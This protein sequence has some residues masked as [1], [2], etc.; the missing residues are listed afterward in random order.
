MLS[1]LLTYGVVHDIIS[2]PR[3]KSLLSMRNKMMNNGIKKINRMKEPLYSEDI[4]IKV[5]VVNT[6]FYEKE[7]AYVTGITQP[8]AN[9]IIVSMKTSRKHVNVG[10]GETFGPHYDGWYI[11]V[12]SELDNDHYIDDELP[13]DYIMNEVVISMEGFRADHA[14]YITVPFGIEVLLMKNT[15]NFDEVGVDYTVID[16][17]NNKDSS[18]IV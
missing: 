15:F 13:D 18:L 9:L 2:N 4:S 1:I 10:L 6:A 12:S 5:H 7:F 8:N 16:W 11:A 17:N 3:Y 14:E